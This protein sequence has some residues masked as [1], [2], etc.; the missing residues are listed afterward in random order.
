MKKYD[1]LLIKIVGYFNEDVLTQSSE[2]DVKD[3][4]YKDNGDN[5]NWWE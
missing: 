5:S 1:E 3:D 4:P 2:A